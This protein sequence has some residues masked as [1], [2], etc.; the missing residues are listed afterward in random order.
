MQGAIG[1]LGG[2]FDPIHSGHLRL[3]Q[4]VAE[5]LALSAVRF[6]P[7]GTPPHRTAPQTTVADRVAMIRLAIADNPLFLLDERETQRGG[8]SYTV[9]TLCELR[10]EWGATRPLVLLMGADA[11][12]GFESWHRWRDIF[13]MAHIAVAHRPGS[14]LGGM[15]AAL[16]AEFTRRRSDDAQV[17]QRAAAGAIIEVP[18]TALDIAATAIRTMVRARR[19]ARYLVPTAVLRYIEDNQLFLKDNI[20]Q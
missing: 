10:A 7:S 8:R 16:A 15:P 13:N 9:D 17:V 20:S 3:A 14:R 6:I 2:T 5:T 18:I 11:F 19:S 12:L 1:I 4:E